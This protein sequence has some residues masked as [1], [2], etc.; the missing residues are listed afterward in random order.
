[1]GLYS[2]YLSSKPQDE[3]HPYGHGKVEFLTS[4]VEGVLIILA[5]LM[6]CIQAIGSLLSPKPIEQPDTGIYLILATGI[7]NYLMGYYSIIKGKKNNSAVLIS[8]GKHL[9]SDTITTA[10]VVVSLVL[11]KLTGQ[12][13]IDPVLAL[14][15]GGY[16]MFTA[17]DIVRS[18]I[19]GIMDETDTTLI[20]QVAEALESEREP[21]WI[22]V[23]SLRVQQ[24][25]AD[26]HIDAHITLPYYYSLREAHGCLE[27][28]MR[29]TAAHIDRKME[30][31]LH[32]DDCKPA[33]C[34]I[35]MKQDCPVRAAAF[36]KRIIW[37]RAAVT[38]STKHGILTQEN[39][40]L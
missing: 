28:L 15:F 21:D 40:E 16:I 24:Y 13:W 5:G 1:M 7:I 26:L 27:S 23:H 17:Y 8:S 10:G 32:M 29:K 30:F 9:Q 20:D 14:A 2:L 3:E 4:A 6:I 37:D 25:G 18:A 36:E 31:N 19:R 22:D 39:S 34:K 12:V 35:C 33:S 11:V 38:A